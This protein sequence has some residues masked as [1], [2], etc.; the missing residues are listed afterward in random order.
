MGK[1]VYQDDEG[2]IVIDQVAYTQ[3]FHICPN[4]DER[5]KETYPD[6]AAIREFKCIGCEKDVPE[7]MKEVLQTLG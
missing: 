7:K 5:R 3:A 4:E 6:Y 1:V 2:W